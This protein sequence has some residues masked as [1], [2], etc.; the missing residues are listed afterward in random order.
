VITETLPHPLDRLR[1]RY[2]AG[3]VCAACLTI[4][5]TRPESYARSGIT[6]VDRLAY[7]CAECRADQAEAARLAAI[8]RA[9]LA[10]A[11]AA[12]QATRQ[13]ITG[14]STAPDET[15]PP[16]VPENRGVAAIDNR[17]AGRNGGTLARAR[18]RLR[19]RG[20]VQRGTRVRRHATVTDGNRA[21]QRAYRLRQQVKA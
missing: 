7:V 11:R 6:E 19:R 9:N 12:R 14:P 13:P 20:Y 8:R 15:P 17:Y 21:R 16:R 1:A 10:H 5:A 3:L 4:L 18:E 2:P